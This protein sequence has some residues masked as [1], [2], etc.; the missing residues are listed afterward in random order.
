MS[1]K[2]KFKKVVQGVKEALSVPEGGW[3]PQLQPIPVRA[4]NNRPS[5]PRPP[6]GW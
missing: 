5:K 4:E 2:Q 3:Q 6:Q 1:F